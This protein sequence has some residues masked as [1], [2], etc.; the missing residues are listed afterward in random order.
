[1]S[2]THREMILNIWRLLRQ[3]FILPRG[4]KIKSHDCVW[5]TIDAGLLG[6]TVCGGVHIC[7]DLKCQDIIETTDGTVCALSGIYIRNK[8]FV[9]TEYQDTVNLTDMKMSHKIIDESVVGDITSI[10]QCILSSEI[11]KK[12]YFEKQLDIVLKSHQKY[13]NHNANTFA[14]CTDIIIHIKNTAHPFEKSRREILA[15]F[16][17]R[18]CYHVLM[19]L[20]H[21][22]GMSIKCSE[23]QDMAIGLLYLM[24]TGVKMNDHTILPALRE[25]LTML[26]PENMLNSYFNIRSKYITESENRTKMCLRIANPQK[27]MATRFVIS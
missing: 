20:V 21:D 26:P 5:Q 13:K 1:M 10:I 22:F 24:R 14:W 6:C 11:A 12:I 15:D 19:L 8:K 3:P 18:Q 7:S 2:N 23:I 17:A 9:D 27:L 25:L 16:C 4:S